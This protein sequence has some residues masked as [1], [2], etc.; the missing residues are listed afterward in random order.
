MRIQN[1]DK[2]NKKNRQLEK[3]NIKSKIKA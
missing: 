2:E 3:K 1:R